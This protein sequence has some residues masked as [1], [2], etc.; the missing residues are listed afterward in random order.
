MSIG[1]IFNKI[2]KPRNSAAFTA[3]N[4]LLGVGPLIIPEPFFRAGFF[5]SL[6]WTIVVCLLSFM[7]TSYIGES[8]ILINRHM[9]EM[10]LTSISDIEPASSAEYI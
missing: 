6:V 5:F 4:L 7:S 10:K 8:I 3:I 2:S 1:E 9:D